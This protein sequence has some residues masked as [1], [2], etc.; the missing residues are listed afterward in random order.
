MA[1][2]NKT[3]L[4]AE[5]KKLGVEVDPAKKLT[6]PKLEK[7]LAKAEGESSGSEEDT[8]SRETPARLKPDAPAKSE[9][10]ASVTAKGDYLQKYQYGKDVPLGDPSTNPSPGSKAYRMKQALLKQEPVKIIVMR[11]PGEAPSI[12]KSINLNGYRLDLPKQEYLEVPEQIAR[13]IMKSQ[14]QQDEALK[15]MRIDIADDKTKKQLGA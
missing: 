11:E 3:Q 15:F 5:L 13:I 2:L 8:E 10:S 6:N 9:A 1:K 7:M 12:L 14:K 4:V